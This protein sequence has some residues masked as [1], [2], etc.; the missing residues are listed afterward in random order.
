MALDAATR[1]LVWRRASDRC[2]YCGLRQ[3]DSPFRTFHIDH[4]IARKHG[5]S[6]RPSNLVLACDPFS[7]PG[8]PFFL[9]RLRLGRVKLL[10]L[11]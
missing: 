8:S 11:V 5:G 4:I 2:E 10:A 7:V 9:H 1:A 6:D 3:I